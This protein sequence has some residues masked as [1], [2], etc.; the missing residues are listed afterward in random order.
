MGGP[1][2]AIGTSYIAN[3]ITSA[4]ARFVSTISAP[5]KRRKKIDG[6]FD[7][8]ERQSA[9]NDIVRARPRMLCFELG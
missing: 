6:A 5:L 1:I 3:L 2:E 7:D 9:G 8:R 4:T